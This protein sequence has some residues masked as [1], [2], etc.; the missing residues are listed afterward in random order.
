MGDKNKIVVLS[1]CHDSDVY[2]KKVSEMHSDADLFLFCGDGLNKFI[3]LCDKKGFNHYEVCG[4]CDYVYGE[5]KKI[6]AFADMTFLMLHSHNC[7]YD[8]MIELAMIENADFLLYGH[9]HVAENIYIPSDELK[10]YSKAR[11][12]GLYVVNPGSITRPKDM[13]MKPSFAL[14]DIIDRKTSVSIGRF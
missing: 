9:T 6:F 1:D 13:F 5:Q 12:K 7:D 14:I 11:N 10:Y 2:L 4:N 3:P 8:E